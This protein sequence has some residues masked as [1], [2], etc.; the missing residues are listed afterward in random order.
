MSIS[1]GIE[2]MIIVTSTFAQVLA[3]SSP[4]VNAICVL[5]VWR[6]IMGVGVGVGG[7]Y[8]LSAVIDSEFA[9]T[10]SRGRLMTTVLTAQSWGNFGTWHR[11]CVEADNAQLVLVVSLVALVTIHAYKNSIIADNF[12]DLK[13][14][15]N[16]WRILVGLGCV[17]G[18]ISLYLR[19]TIPETPR[20]TMDIDR[21]VQRAKNDIENVLG[22]NGA[23]TTVNWVDPNAVVQRA[24]APRRS[25][26]DFIKYFAQPGN[27]LLLFG[28]AYSWF[29]IDAGPISF[30][31]P[32]DAVANLPR[33]QQVAF[34]GLGLIRR[35]F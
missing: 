34:Y 29:A 18:A 28:V 32:C 14:V 1:D 26:S 3:G 5:V 8:P 12:G 16:C 23:S 21:N 33:R 17:M 27:L 31:R 6:F 25:R 11:S 22:P 7:D 35:R 30:I 20:F 2:L 13:H 4:G 15:D 24:E 10:G 9:S 19:L